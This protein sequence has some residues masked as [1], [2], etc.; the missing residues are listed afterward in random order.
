MKTKLMVM[1]CVLFMALVCQGMARAD[2]F[3]GD[4]WGTDMSFDVVEI[5]PEQLGA[6]AV[7]TDGV[8]VGNFGWVCG[9]SDDGFRHS[10]DWTLV[11]AID[12]DALTMFTPIY[13]VFWRN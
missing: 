3:S 11:F 1:V 10:A 5:I 7:L 4:Y 12:G 2:T 9:P 6:M 8:Y 13:A